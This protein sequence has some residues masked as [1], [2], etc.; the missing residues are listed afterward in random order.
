MCVHTYVWVHVHMYVRACVC[1]R[2][3]LLLEHGERLVTE[4]WAPSA[5]MPLKKALPFGTDE[6]ANKLV[7][8]I[9]DRLQIEFDSHRQGGCRELTVAVCP[10]NSMHLL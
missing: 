1:A 8:A 3:R 4:A 10:V 7:K 5:S 6:M 2:V 9:A